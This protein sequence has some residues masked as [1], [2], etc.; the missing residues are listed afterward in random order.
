MTGMI[1]IGA[2]KLAVAIL[3]TT[4]LVAVGAGGASA[5]EVIYNNMNTVPATVNG[6]PN[7][8]TFSEGFEC[9]GNKSIG[10]EIQTAGAARTI[11]SLAVQ[12][13]SFKCEEGVYYFENCRTSR[14]KKFSQTF[15]VKVYEVTGANRRGTPLAEATTTAKIPYRPTTN[16][17]CPATGE[18]KGFGPNCDVGGYL[19][20]VKFKRLPY[21]VLPH[22]GRALVEFETTPEGDVN[23]GLEESYKEYTGGEYIGEPGSGAPTVGSEPDP[24]ALFRNGVAVSPGYEGAQP[25]MEVIA[26]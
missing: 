13:D 26:K 9:C 23:I 21:N 17:S 16:V 1:P 4:V 14:N 2:G 12:V 15:T 6:S 19:A 24:S 11:K 18:G 3:A 8:D 10:G 22:S 20:T 7:L 5:A 25:V